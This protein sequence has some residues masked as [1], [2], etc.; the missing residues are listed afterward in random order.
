MPEEVYTDR[1]EFLDYFY[2]YALKATTRRAMSSVLPGQR[3][4][5]KTEIFKRGVNRLFFLQ[6]H[7]DPNA[8][9]PIYYS[10][11]DTKLDRQD[12][13]L[14][15]VENF[16]RWYAAFRL[17]KP[18]LLSEP[19]TRDALVREIR[20]SM[21]V[22]EGF[23]RALNLLTVID[24]GNVTLPQERALHLPRRV[25]VG[26]RVVRK[27]LALLEKLKDFEG[28]EYFDGEHPLT[29]HIWLFAHNGVTGQA[30]ALLRQHGIYW[31]DRAD[32]DALIQLTGL[33][34]LPINPENS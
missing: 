28:R 32:L 30:A 6:D 7:A 8:A 19:D 21:T 4:M 23:S 10:F 31:S 27:L 17:R 33:R 20:S 1:Q 3:R 2:E 24:S 14:T 15:Y 13:A 9:V 22:S 26:V 16:V 12:F 5:G 34:K 25:K 18:S 11:Q 29:V